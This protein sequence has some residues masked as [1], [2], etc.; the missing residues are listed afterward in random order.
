MTV[1][2]S[3]EFSTPELLLVLGTFG[4]CIVMGVEDPYLGMMFE[5]VRISQHLALI[6]LLISLSIFN[7]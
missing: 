7:L 5:E 6:S 2:F 1:E 4:P 3:I